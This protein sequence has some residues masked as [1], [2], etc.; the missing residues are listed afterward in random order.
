[1]AV[2]RAER[3]RELGAEGLN[4]PSS[5]NYFVF[6][7]ALV[8]VLKLVSPFRVSLCCLC[9]SPLEYLFHS[10]LWSFL[11]FIWGTVLSF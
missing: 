4:V 10:K 11:T 3:R 8:W 1:M 5:Q 6:R 9:D 7:Y 2:K